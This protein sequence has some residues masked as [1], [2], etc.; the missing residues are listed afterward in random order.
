MK[1]HKAVLDIAAHLVHLN[2]PMYEKVTQHL[3][4][5]SRM[6]ASLHH[7]V[8]KRLEEIHV[9]RE[10]L[11]VFPDDLLGMPPKRTIEFNIELQP[12]TISIAKSPYRIMP[13]ELVELT[14]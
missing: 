4:A 5:I 6:K 3:H 14:I 1:C 8:L 13:V 7:M 9:V 12:D 10:F 11:D 2:P